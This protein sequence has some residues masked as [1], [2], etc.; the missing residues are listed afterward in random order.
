MDFFYFTLQCCKFIIIKQV[1]FFSAAKDQVNVMVA[2][3][4]IFNMMYHT[5]ERSYT[6][7]G[8]DQKKI[9]IQSRRE[10]KYSLR[11]TQSQLTPDI[12][13]IKKILSAG[14]TLVKN[15]NKF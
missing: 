15:D 11:A 6:S 8:A 7:A 14:P 10:G 4:F 1:F 5:S 9:F 2:D 13:M 3:F 12:H